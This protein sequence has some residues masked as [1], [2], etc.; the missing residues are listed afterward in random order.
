MMS[1]G[2]PARDAAAAACRNTQHE[3]DEISEQL[4]RLRNELPDM[5][6]RWAVLYATTQIERARDACHAAADD[7]YKEEEKA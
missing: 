3:L 1:Y 5:R 7:L 4:T 2:Q 6:D